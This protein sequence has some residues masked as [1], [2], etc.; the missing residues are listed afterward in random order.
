MAGK[1]K[2][3]KP[4]QARSRA[5]NRCRNKNKPKTCSKKKIKTSSKTRRSRSH[6]GT[7]P[8]I[9]EVTGKIT[10]FQSISDI[11]LQEFERVRNS[12]F[13][14]NVSENEIRKIGKDMIDIL[15]GVYKAA[16]A[17]NMDLQGRL[18]FL[19]KTNCSD[20]TNPSHD[21]AC[22][23]SLVGP[24]DL[25]FKT[26]DPTS[27]LYQQ[28]ILWR[29]H[30]DSNNY[31]QKNDLKWAIAQSLTTH[32][33][34]DMCFLGERGFT[35]LFLGKI[36]GAPE[37][38]ESLSMDSMEKEVDRIFSNDYNILGSVNNYLREYGSI[39]YVEYNAVKSSV[40]QVE[41]IHWS[42]A[43]FVTGA[44]STYYFNVFQREYVRDFIEN[45]IEA[46][47]SIIKRF[48]DKKTDSDDVFD[49]NPLYVDPDLLFTGTQFENTENTENTEQL[50]IDQLRT[51]PDI[52]S[53]EMS[54]ALQK[55]QIFSPFDNIQND[56]EFGETYKFVR[57][58][59]DSNYENFRK[60]Y[61][62]FLDKEFLK[63]QEYMS[64]DPL[65]IREAT[66]YEKHLLNIKYLMEVFQHYSEVF[67]TYLNLWTQGVE[68]GK[69]MANMVVGIVGKIHSTSVAEYGREFV[70]RGNFFQNYRRNRYY[71][72]KYCRQY[73]YK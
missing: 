16:S 36:V 38:F 20:T 41:A 44:I 9:T 33:E 25:E 66:S 63:T 17:N 14:P 15:H 39:E 53:G 42:Y 11:V 40:R 68:N 47:D 13:V 54:T 69:N 70:E 29:T 31:F 37:D 34:L 73:S 8:I 62:I 1:L 22:G 64:Q 28:V 32:D 51:V 59:Q 67:P 72:R 46:M 26:V 3:C 18:N 19:E 21:M 56:L 43:V 27:N 24:V 35:R 55:F 6:K 10:S 48:S 5:T 49:E 61:G 71:E 30:T 58:I 23:L 57:G 2:P 60:V 7:G 45:V 52:P 65:M 4:H 50:L 12:Q